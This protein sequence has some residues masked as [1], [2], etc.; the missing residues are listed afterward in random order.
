MDT[1][2]VCKQFIRGMLCPYYYAGLVF[3]ILIWYYSRSHLQGECP[4]VK[5]TQSMEMFLDYDFEPMR[6]D[7]YLSQDFHSIMGLPEDS[8]GNQNALYDM[9]E[10]KQFTPIINNEQSQAAF[11]MNQKQN[12]ISVN[13]NSEQ[14]HTALHVSNE[15]NQ[16]ILSVSKEQNRT[17]FY[18]DNEESYSASSMTTER[19]QT[20]FPVTE[21]NSTAQHKNIKQ[22]YTTLD[23]N[24]NLATHVNKE[25]VLTQTQNS[26]LSHV[27]VDQDFTPDTDSLMHQESE[28]N[29]THLHA[30]T[31][32][33]EP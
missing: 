22:N 16:T 19:N 2:Y 7:V 21:D 15:L 11:D 29:Q 8:E 9:N 14:N 5:A 10:E 31:W 25:L 12:Q 23:N 6:E 1:N 32:Q 30:P 3:D 4:V 27:E 18:T 28:R 33:R 13:I 20:S 26:N 17:A 24:S